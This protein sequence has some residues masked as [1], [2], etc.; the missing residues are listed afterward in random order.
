M[1]SLMLLLGGAT[2]FL[3]HGIVWY[4]ITRVSLYAAYKN[5]VSAFYVKINKIIDEEYFLLR[6]FERNLTGGAGGL[7]CW[8]KLLFRFLSSLSSKNQS[9]GFESRAIKIS[10]FDNGD[11]LFQGNVPYPRGHDKTN[12]TS[13]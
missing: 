2:S 8:N 9:H 4:E 7:K 13:E 12:N 5:D 10:E 11:F 3:L 1:N 6:K